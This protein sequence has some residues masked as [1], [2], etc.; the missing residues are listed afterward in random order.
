MASL[1]AM[2]NYGP[3]KSGMDDYKQNEVRS[4]TA[5]LRIHNPNTMRNRSAQ[6]SRTTAN[7]TVSTN[8]VGIR[9]RRNS[10]Q[11]HNILKRK[12]V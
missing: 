9:K 3:G 6:R 10:N 8:N 11:T 4:S 5:Q 1:T 7:T 12:N 2:T